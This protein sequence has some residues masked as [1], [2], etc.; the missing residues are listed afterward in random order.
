MLSQLCTKFRST[1]YNITTLSKNIT[2]TSTP[3]RT[4]FLPGDNNGPVGLYNDRDYWKGK[5]FVLDD[6]SKKA[7]EE[8]IDIQSKTY[9]SL[10]KKIRHFGG[11]MEKC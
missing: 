9:A 2:V 5:G 4:F 1:S 6:N 8:Y 3:R 10:E 7:L 11:S